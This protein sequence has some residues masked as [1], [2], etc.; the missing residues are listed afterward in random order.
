M[1]PPGPPWRKPCRP[2]MI[3]VPRQ[4]AEPKARNG[5]TR[6]HMNGDAPP[7]RAEPKARNGSTGPHMSGDAP[8]TYRTESSEWVFAAVHCSILP[9]LSMCISVAPPKS[10]NLV[11]HLSLNFYSTNL[12]D[13]FCIL[14]RGLRK[15][16]TGR[17]RGEKK[18]F[19]FLGFGYEGRKSGLRKLTCGPTKSRKNIPRMLSLDSFVKNLSIPYFF[20]FF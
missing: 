7:T 2:N 19:N 5:F 6:P 17:F 12:I 14:S 9:E 4:R 10:V 16:R 15:R 13:F 8:P 1:V 20:F 11:D 18:I 3:R